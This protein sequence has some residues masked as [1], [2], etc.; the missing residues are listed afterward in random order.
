[1]KVRI[2]KSIAG[3]AM[4]QYGITSI[5]ALQPGDVLD[6]HDELARKWISSRIAKAVK[7]AAQEGK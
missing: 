4:P 3:L 2:L 1:M 5:F 7:P 6:L